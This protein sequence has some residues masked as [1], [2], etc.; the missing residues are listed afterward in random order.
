MRRRD[1]GIC[2]A[3]TSADVAADDHIA[4]LHKMLANTIA[5]VASDL[6]PDTA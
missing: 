6:A 3:Q 2:D 4:S 1:Q 5:S